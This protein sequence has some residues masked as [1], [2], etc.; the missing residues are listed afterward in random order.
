VFARADSVNIKVSAFQNHKLFI[1]Y[2]KFEWTT[3]QSEKVMKK[4]VQKIFTAC[5]DA[6]ITLFRSAY[7]LA[8]E[9]VSLIK[10][11]SLWKLFLQ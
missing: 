6:L 10:F 11:L 8:K 5:D 3:N 2:K 4:I 9:I 1:E 7:F